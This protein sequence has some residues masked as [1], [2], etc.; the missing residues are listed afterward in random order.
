MFYFC[1]WLSNLGIITVAHRDI[2]AGLVMSSG[3]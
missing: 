2:A 3:I 1:V